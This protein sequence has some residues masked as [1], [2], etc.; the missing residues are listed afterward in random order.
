MHVGSYGPEP[1]TTINPGENAAPSPVNIAWNRPAE[2]CLTFRLW[3]GRRLGHEAVRV[4]VHAGPEGLRRVPRETELHDV[5]HFHLAG[6]IHNEFVV[7]EPTET[8][9]ETAVSPRFPRGGVPWLL[10]DTNADLDSGW[11]AIT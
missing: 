4:S 10:S 6:V 2:S 1:N 7:L 5:L 8:G 9:G 11:T 3:D